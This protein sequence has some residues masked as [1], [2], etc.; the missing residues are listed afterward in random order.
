[1]VQQFLLVGL[2]GFTGA[3][4]RFGLSGLVQNVSKNYS[5]PWPTLAV[6]LFGC[7]LIGVLSQLADSFGIFTTEARL[8]VFIGFLG[9][10]TTYSTFSNETM[11]LIRGGESLLS[12]VYVGL[13]LL[14][15]LGSVWLGRMAAAALTRL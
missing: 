8:F 3:V 7:L 2:G 15:G 4:L 11:D 1:M 12:L 14:L 10:F 5:F 9:A 13:H 6:N